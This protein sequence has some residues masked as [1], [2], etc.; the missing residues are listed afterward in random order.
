M[1]I[2]QFLFNSG[3]LHKVQKPGRYLGD[4][5]NQIDKK[6]EHTISLCFPDLYEIGMSHTGFQ[7]LY[8][9][10]NNSKENVSCERV[11]LPWKD[12]IEQLEKND[13]DLFTLE[14]YKAIRETDVLAFTVQY[15]L[16]Y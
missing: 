13:I 16:I 9:L 5:Y 8:N 14:S 11:F 10:F 6:A 1:T 2:P 15:E 4:E 7:I 12:M 3:T